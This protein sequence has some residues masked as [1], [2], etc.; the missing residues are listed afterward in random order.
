MSERPGPLHTQATPLS[1][2]CFPFAQA[3]F[4]PLPHRG[5][6]VHGRKTHRPNRYENTP[7]TERQSI[8]IQPILGIVAVI[9]PVRPARTG[10][11]PARTANAHSATS[12]G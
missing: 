4:Q 9:V 10:T 3:S 2:H 8:Q 12:A 5:L 11:A 1:V 7:M 6:P